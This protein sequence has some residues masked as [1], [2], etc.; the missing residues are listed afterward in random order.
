MITSRFLQGLA[1]AGIL[2]LLGLGIAAGPLKQANAQTAQEIGL[3][4]PATAPPPL[5][6]VMPDERAQ[7]T[8][9]RDIKAR[10]RLTIDI[11]ETHLSRAEQLT[12][13]K[14]FDGACAE[15]GKY[16]GVIEDAFQFLSNQ[17]QPSR[18]RDYYKRL[19]LALREHGPRIEALRRVTP[20]EFAVHTKAVADYTR[21]A[22]TEALD[23]FYG[24]TVIREVSQD[25]KKPGGGDMKETSPAP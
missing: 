10:V 24:D 13:Q 4:L 14:L 1:R 25:R 11:A 2:A 19:E 5:R 9:A 17:R 7:L 6:L 12:A 16:R 22:R 20:L 3:E 8:S 23:S 15:L 21:A 18:M